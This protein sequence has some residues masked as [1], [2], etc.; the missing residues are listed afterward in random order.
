M[1]NDPG[2]LI[3]TSVAEPSRTVLMIARTAIS[4][5]SFRVSS[6]SSICNRGL[7]SGV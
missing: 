4:Q 6:V 2:A 7:G 1:G 5:A 3:C